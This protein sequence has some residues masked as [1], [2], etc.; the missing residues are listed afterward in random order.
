[1]TQWL[2]Y[3]VYGLSTQLQ[4]VK[5]LGKQAIE[6]DIM[7]KQYHLSDRQKLA[8]EYIYKHGGITIQQFENICSDVARFRV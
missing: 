5:S 8:I 4:E 3:F 1:M 7:I 6:Q 2:E